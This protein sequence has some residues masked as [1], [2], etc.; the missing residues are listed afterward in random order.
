VLVAESNGVGTLGDSAGRSDDPIEHWKW[1]TWPTT[2]WTMT[3]A[4]WGMPRL[5]KLKVLS[6]ATT[7]SATSAIALAVAPFAGTLTSLVLR[8]NRIS[9][10]GATALLGSPLGR[11]GVR[12][13]LEGNPVAEELLA[14]LRDREETADSAHAEGGP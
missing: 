13:N 5:A 1:L 11:Q 8:G 10:T 9:D 3:R 12:L 4:P 6:L 7:P 2:N 14:R